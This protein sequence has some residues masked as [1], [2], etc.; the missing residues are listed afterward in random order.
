V[1]QVRIPSQLR[2]R[3]SAQLI[4]WSL[5]SL[6]ALSDCFIVRHY[7]LAMLYVLPMLVLG[8]TSSTLVV[9]ATGVICSVLR[10]SFAPFSGEPGWPIRVCFSALSFTA[11]G[12]FSG[13]VTAR[14]AL[15]R[16]HSVMEQDHAEWRVASEEHMAAI[17]NTT[18]LAVI[19]VQTDG[20]ALIVNRSAIKIL[21]LKTDALDGDTLAERLPELK[22]RLQKAGQSSGSQFFHMVA[23]RSDGAHLYCRAWLSKHRTTSGSA[24]TCV[25]SDESEELRER[26]TEALE[27]LTTASDLVIAAAMHEVRNLTS[28]AVMTCEGMLHREHFR[29]NSEIRIVADLMRAVQKLSSKGLKSFAYAA[30]PSSTVSLD[31]ILQD[32]QVVIEPACRRLNIELVWDL[33]PVLPPVR[34]DQ[35]SVLQVLLNLLRNS[36]RALD[37]VEK[38]AITVS[39]STSQSKVSVYVRDTGPGVAHPESLFKAYSEGA[40]DSGLGLFISRALAHGL[41]GDLQ[42]EAQLNG[43]CFRFDLLNATTVDDV[44]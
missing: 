44:G 42:Y 14:R 19:T 15:Q 39:T 7:S 6:I 9:V 11:V 18:P 1:R 36:I 28:A 13:E 24:F 12:L 2:G 4:G 5:L 8:R 33:L 3:K 10:E 25:F 27:W 17:V 32:I 20:R 40:K 34:G 35:H 43:A 30:T 23:T 16:K 26:Q 37:H 31:S 22:R 21:G 29:D 38:R 41:G